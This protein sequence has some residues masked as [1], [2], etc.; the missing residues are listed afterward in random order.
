MTATFNNLDSD[1]NIIMKDLPNWKDYFL[2]YTI[3]TD[4]TRFQSLFSQETFTII[5]ASDGGVHNYEGTYGVVLSNGASQFA[6][7]HGKIYSVDFCESSY[8]LEL[9][10]MLAG[11]LTFKSLHTLSGIDSS[12]KIT[13]K[14]FSDNKELVKKVNN[15]L[16]NTRKT[17][18]H[19]NSDVDLELKLMH[20]IQNL[21]LINITISVGLV[22]SHQEMRKVKSKLSHIEVLNIIAD[23][24]TKKA[25]KYRL[26]STNS[27]LHKNPIDFTINNVTINSKYALCSKK[28][29]HSISL[30]SYLQEKHA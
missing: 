12:T 9:Y 3:I 20:E 5:I 25:R 29:F 21:L 4:K 18:Q 27:S 16:R 6:T 10:A 1:K 26:K 8:R 19:R 14:I 24:L 15:R 28:A 2:K 23:D 30:R 13:V 7:N 22:R 17:N 11:I